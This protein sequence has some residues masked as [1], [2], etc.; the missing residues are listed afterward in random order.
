MDFWF[1]LLHLFTDPANCTISTWIQ[2][3][4]LFGASA[5]KCKENLEFDRKRFEIWLVNT[6]QVKTKGVGKL[7]LFEHIR[8]YSSTKAD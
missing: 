1:T 8:M 5:R 7:N 3:S 4:F 6:G 2:I